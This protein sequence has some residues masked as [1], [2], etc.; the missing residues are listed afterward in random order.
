MKKIN[1]LKKW[2]KAKTPLYARILQSFS[3]AVGALPAYYSALPE[4]F[5]LIIPDNVVMIVSFCGF[6]TTFF[7]NFFHIKEK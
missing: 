7:L 4:R 5:Q 2:W 6:L 1:K 3:L